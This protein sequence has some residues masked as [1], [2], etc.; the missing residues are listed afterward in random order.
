MEKEQVEHRLIKPGRYGRSR[1][2]GWV[3]DTAGGLSTASLNRDEIAGAESA[4]ESAA[5]VESEHHLNTPGQW[6]RRIRLWRRIERKKDAGRLSTVSLNRDDGAEDTVLEQRVSTVSLN[7]DDMAGAE[8]TAVAEE[9]VV[10]HCL[11]K[12]GRYGRSRGY[13]W[14]ENL[15]RRI[16][17]RCPRE[18]L[19]TVSLNRDETAGAESAAEVEE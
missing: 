9:E 1:E 13:G 5:E 19:G 16:Q 7:R 14:V 6:G 11:I 10:E 15:E 17:G 3:E 12:L 8:D 2:Y 4:E 18:E